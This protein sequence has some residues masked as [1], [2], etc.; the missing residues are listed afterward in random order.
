MLFDFF[1]KLTQDSDPL[2][3]RIIFLHSSKFDLFMS[4]LKE[5]KVFAVDIESYHPDLDYLALDPLSLSIRLLQIGLPDSVLIVDFHTTIDYE[6]MYSD[7]LVSLFNLLKSKALDKECKVLGHNLKYDLLA[8]RRLGLVFHNVRDTMLISQILWSGVGVMSAKSK[9]MKERSQRCLIS[10]SLKAVAERVGITLDKSEQ[11]S[12]WSSNILTNNQFNY[13]AKDVLVLFE[14]FEKLQQKV[15]ELSGSNSAVWAE[16]LALPSFVE[17]EFNGFPVDLEL[18]Q[19]YLELYNT[20]Y[21]RLTSVWSDTFGELNPKSTKKDLVPAIKNTLGFE[22]E[23]STD[24]ALGLIEHEAIKALLKMRS[25]NIS[26]QYLENIIKKATYSENLKLGKV[27]RPMFRQI[28][29]GW[30]T[31]CDGKISHSKFNPKTGKTSRAKKESL[32]YMNLQQIPNKAYNGLPNIR[33]VFKAPEN[34]C[35]LIADLSQSHARIACELSQDPTL[36]KAYN[37]GLDNHLIIA[38]K[39]L[40]LEGKDLTFEEVCSIYK[41]SK[42]LDKSQWSE[43]HSLIKEKRDLAKTAFYAFLNQAGAATMKNTFK[44]NGIDVS[45]DKCKEVISLL[46][47][48]YSGLYNYIKTETYKANKEDIFFKD[49]STTTG[50]QLEKPYGRVKNLTGNYGYFEKMPS[51]FE[52]KKGNKYPDQIPYTEGIAWRWL[53]SEAV[54]IKTALGNIAKKMYYTDLDAKL[55]GFCHDEINLVSHESCASE[56]AKLVGTELKLALSKYIKTIPV[57]ESDNYDSFIVKSLADK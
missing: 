7:R 42:K 15:F 51:M 19:Q 56:V 29:S 10:H 20:E 47:E 41:E 23:D 38:T 17:I 52:D 45:E 24:A 43:S 50:L 2:D 6:I 39:I 49:I 27:V 11:L 22:V 53:S 40:V 8:L 46:R 44:S 31:G 54:M 13:A 55:V 12:D 3:P 57:E 26:I 33:E 48:T 5:A 16:C 28:T 21:S 14:I 36:L 1:K 4:Q 9:A 30:R 25:L 37:E 18:A 34:Y 32:F 35:L